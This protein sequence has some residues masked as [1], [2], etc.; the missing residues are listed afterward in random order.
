MNEDNFTYFSLSKEIEKA[1]DQLG[2]IKPTPIQK[3]AIP[4][5]LNG[6]SII[7]RSQTGSGKTHAYLLPLF[8]QLDKNLN[9]VQIVITLP[10]R[11]LA[12]QIFQEV[13]NM[14]QLLN[15]ESF[16][17]AKLLIGGMD[18]QRMI[19]ELK[20]PPHIVVGTPGRILDLIN[21]EVLTI[22]TAESFVI[23][24]ADLMLD[25]GFIET[26]D[27]LL[28]RSKKD[29]Q[30]LVFSATIP[31]RLEHF[32]KKYLKQPI[33]VKIEDEI[34]PK[35]IEHRLIAKKY[36]NELQILNEIRSSIQPYLAIVFT[37]GKETAEIVA[38]ELQKND[39]DAVVL[40][41]GLTPRERKRNLKKILQLECHYIVA[42]DLASRGIDIK[43]VSHVI[44]LELPKE[45]HFYVHRAG[46]TARAGM[47]GVV[48]SIY[49]EQDIPLIKNLENKGIYF[50]Y[51]EVKDGQ[52]ETVR[53]WNYRKR[54]KDTF[55]SRIEDE[56]WKRVK[57]PKKIKPGY[58][59]KMKQEQ[60]KIKK[61]LIK[62]SKSKRK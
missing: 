50:Q 37:N 3:K 35:Q 45:E 41:G 43:G 20:N 19:R 52:W 51:V 47:D 5:I 38:T 33:Y 29:I 4:L 2:F 39:V 6:E 58:K 1:I 27:Q 18:K 59:K 44:N 21:E 30:L 34:V 40:H 11:E 16:I 60:Q 31:M 36:R 8:N 10:T 49:D 13:K 25:L 22:Y 56:A 42:T 9:E 28:V 61:K 32:L 57:K 17:T 14:I 26:I 15:Q 54:R 7:G 62:K 53:E 46:R 55:S 24:E 48:I 23:D 12:T